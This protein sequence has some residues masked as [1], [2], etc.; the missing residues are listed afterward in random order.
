MRMLFD[1]WLP[2]PF[3]VATWIE[4]SFTTAG[5]LGVCGGA[6]SSRTT[7]TNGS[8]FGSVPCKFREPLMI[9]KRGAKRGRNGREGRRLESAAEVSP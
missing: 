5:P 6:F 7:L 9:T 3:A 2:D 4:K 1:D 8:F